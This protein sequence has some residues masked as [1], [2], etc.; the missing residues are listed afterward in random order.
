[1]SELADCLFSSAHFHVFHPRFGFLNCILLHVTEYAST[2][3]T[4]ILVHNKW[5]P[6]FTKPLLEGNEER[7]V[8]EVVPSTFEDLCEW[9]H[10]SQNPS[11]V[12]KTQNHLLLY[13][14]SCSDGIESLYPVTIHV[15]GL[16]GKFNSKVFGSWTGI[17]KTIPSAI[18]YVN[19]KGCNHWEPW[20]SALHAIKNLRQIIYA[21]LGDY[22][23]V[24]ADPSLNH[25]IFMQCQVFTKIRKDNQNKK[26]VLLPSDN[27][28]CWMKAVDRAWGV[29]DKV[30]IARCDKSGAIVSS[31]SAVLSPGDFV[32]VGFTFDISTTHNASGLHKICAYLNI[33]HVLQLVKAVEFA[34]RKAVHADIPLLPQIELAKKQR[35][36]GDSS[37]SL[38][39][40][41]TDASSNF[42]SNIGE[43]QLRDENEN[44]TFRELIPVVSENVPE[45]APALHSSAILG[46]GTITETVAKT[47]DHTD[48]ELVA[49]DEAQLA[50]YDTL[51]VARLCTFANYSDAKNLIYAVENIPPT[52]TWGIFK[53]IHDKSTLLCDPLSNM[54][55]TVWL[56]GVVSRVWMFD[57]KGK[58]R[59]HPK[60]FT[61]VYD[62]RKV[63]NPKS[64]MDYYSATNLQMGDTVLMEAYIKHYCL[65]SDI[66]NLTPVNKCPWRGWKAYFELKCI[67]LIHT[68]LQDDKVEAKK[69]EQ[70]IH[71]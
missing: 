48:K 27:P 57:P 15:Q 21:A 12:N 17:Q 60:P 68:T 55:C 11:E 20:V 50:T 13:K 34:K 14:T 52:A 8:W 65:R 66:D 58:T 26:S 1:M 19:L 54:P 9:A 61:D 22:Q 28:F 25:N 59:A 49:M 38:Q 2:D 5:P 33:E 67:S 37:N 16:L 35:F 47:N 71:I 69:D 43:G 53:P 7:K 62:A 24:E 4:G 30:Q 51:T 10:V 31:L 6:Q 70:H 41:I 63:F 36:N 64:E 45:Q 40:G 29:T 56:P 3:T 23:H 18:Q 42:N 44:T 39:P 32:N 46:D